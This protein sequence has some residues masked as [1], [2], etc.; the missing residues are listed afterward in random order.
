MSWRHQV[1][2]RSTEEGNF[3]ELP[4]TLMHVCFRCNVTVCPLA[5][6]DVHIVC[7]VH[8]AAATT[9]PPVLT[10]DC[11]SPMLKYRTEPPPGLA[12]LERDMK[13]TGHGLE[14]ISLS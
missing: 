8:T 9:L 2:F 3:A 12:T 13:L 5:C 6:Y 14:D 11:S 7:F 1:I 4:P 10:A